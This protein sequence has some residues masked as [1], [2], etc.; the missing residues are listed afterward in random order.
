MTAH[1][2]GLGVCSCK[3]NTDVCMTSSPSP[4]AHSKK[5]SK[6]TL[7]QLSTDGTNPHGQQ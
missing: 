6:G 1:V 3:I 7:T 5:Q 4:H 2:K